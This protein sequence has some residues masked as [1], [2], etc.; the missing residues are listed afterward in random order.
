[1]REA[2][3]RVL[4]TAP[5]LAVA[6]FAQ[7]EGGFDAGGIADQVR[8]YVLGIAGAGVGVLA[9]TIGL[10]AAWKYARRFLKG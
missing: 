1:V 4:Y 7:A 6:A 10:M 2:L 5:V 9:L 8:T 3:K